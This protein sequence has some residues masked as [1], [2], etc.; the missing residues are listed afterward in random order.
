MEQFWQDIRYSLRMLA[1]NPGFALVVVLTLG[2]GIGANT[3]IFTIVDRMLLRPLPVKNP[4]Q[5]VV[6]AG[7]DPSLPFLHPLSYLDMKDFRE[8]TKDS[9]QDMAGYCLEFVGMSAD[10]RP[11]RLTV[12]FVTGN[13]FP[14]L[15]VQPQAGRLI[16]PS[17][18]ETAGADPVIVLGNSYWKRRFGGDPNI[19][20][21][22]VQIDGQPFTVVGVVPPEFL[23]AYTLIEMDGYIPVNMIGLVQDGARYLTSRQRRN[24]HVLA[25]LKPGVSLKRAESALQLVAQRLD[26]QYPDTNSRTTM[27]LLPERM[28]RPEEDGGSDIA[29][30]SGIFLGLVGLVLLLA[31]VNVA[32]IL[33]ARGTMRQ[34]ELAIRS[35]MGARRD[36]LV[37]QLLTEI[38]LLALMGGVAGL[39]IGGLADRMISA[40]PLAVQLPIRL[41][42]NADWRVILFAV[43]VSLAAALLAGL[44]PAL[45]TV[46]ADLQSTLREG[47]RGN[48]GGR[49][50]HRM[51]NVL[52]GMQVALSVMLLVAA[53]LFSASFM[54]SHAMDLGF[55]PHGLMNAVVD[56]QFHGYNEDQGRAFY[57]E[58]L[59]KVRALPGVEDATLALSV[60]MGYNGAGAIVDLPTDVSGPKQEKRVA[61]F[62]SVEPNYFQV[63]RIPIIEGRALAD[64]D[65][66]NSSRVAVI[67][68]TLAKRLW[69][70]QDPIGKLFRMKRTNEAIMEVVGV[71]KTGKYNGVVEDPQPFFY[72][73]VAQDYRSMRTLQ[74]RSLLPAE[75]IGPMVVKAIRDMD[76][77]LPIYDIQTMDESLA[78]VN[79]F[80]LFKLGAYIAA[81]LGLLGLTLAVVGVYGVVSHVASQRTHEIGLRM[82]LGAAP[83]DILA[84]VL[85]SGLGVVLVGTFVGLAGALGVTQ[86][87]ASLLVGVRTYDP[88]TYIGVALLLTA[89]AMLACYIPARRAM[90][91][92]PMVAL[93]YE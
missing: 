80:F 47:G 58:L 12:S 13:F 7:E 71:T 72:I 60:P 82:A 28:A 33:L 8:Q 15:G 66:Q 20:G 6:P 57:R 86:L 87:L 61:Q 25:R 48:S 35:A 29:F 41:D 63:M 62:N 19:V 85:R 76:A 69:P 30:V 78:G 22:A 64:T 31:C 89:V 74:V 5:L 56:V 4:E 32:N 24:M 3:T 53:G 92:D 38:V 52:V 17:E 37:R 45:R 46:R 65:T 14:M 54:R 93:R 9:F 34:K 75:T 39:F 59:H 67:N 55:E 27:H 73:P 36:R 42:F 49:E 79:G 50:H 70:G 1:K 2:L 91:V 81:A 40:I 88:P 23:G 90:R 43:G 26:Q 77:N 11:E 18:G 10:S 21:K 84:M 16:L 51:R 83:R 68:D 44:L